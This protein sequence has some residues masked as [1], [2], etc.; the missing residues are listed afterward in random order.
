MSIKAGKDISQN[1]TIRLA[2]ASTAN[3]TCEVALLNADLEEVDVA[4]FNISLQETASMQHIK[5]GEMPVGD[6]EVLI[7]NSDG[8]C[9]ECD[10]FTDL[11]CIALNGCWEYIISAVVGLAV[12]GLL[13][14]CLICK[15]VPCRLL[16]CCVKRWCKSEE[17]KNKS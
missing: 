7:S 9:P 6:S 5:D 12:L 13:I 2:D 17:N 16:N 3:F 14:Y 11:L 10:G 4:S 15:C 1:I 8:K